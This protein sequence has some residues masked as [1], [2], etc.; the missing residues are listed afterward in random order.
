MK[1][2]ESRAQIALKNILF[3]TD[4]EVSAS[5]ALPF[6]VALAKRYG[7]KLY[8][9]HVIPPE[10]YALASPE[11]AS[12]VLAEAGDF[13]GYS[14]NQLVGPL[15]SHGLSCDTL[16]GE[17]NVAEV[18]QKFAEERAADL[19]VVGTSSRMGWGKVFLGSVAEEII[20]ESPCPVL[21]VGPHVTTLASDG[22]RSVVCATDLSD[23]SARAT[24]FAISLADEYQAHLTF[25]HVSHGIP[26][27]S[28]N[29]T[30]QVIEKRILETIPPEPELPYRPEIVVETGSVADRIL[31]LATDLSTDIIV[32]GA[33][34]VG[35]FAETA[36]H[37]GS[38]AHKVISLAPCPVL[39]ASDVHEAEQK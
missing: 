15:R 25:V 39:T 33:H 2:L 32:M 7:A 34:G 27:D 3:A 17:G 21:A 4:F 28:L 11:S 9:V 1:T 30:I 13:A 23:A 19:L 24:Q 29:L 38:I 35:S 26:R 22:I 18:I 36:S 16:L 20:R 31:N 10:A 5:R 6:A 8:A 14:L 37:F 12:R